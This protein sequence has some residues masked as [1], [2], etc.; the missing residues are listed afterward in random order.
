[1]TSPLDL[2]VEALASALRDQDLTAAEVAD[3]AIA[4]HEA[5]GESLGAYKHFDADGAREA[6][7]AAD[8]RLREPDAPPLCGIPVSVKDL[9]G[10]EGMPTFAGSAR[11]LPGAWSRDAWLV[12]KLREQGAILMGKTHTVEFAYGG[13]G[14]NP[15]WGTPRN[16]WDAETHRIPGGSSAGAGVSLWEGSALIALGS[17]TGGSIRIP[18]SMTGTV[19]HKQ[20]FGRWSTEGV[21]PLS[22]TLDTVGALTRTVEDSVYFFGAL[23]PEWGDPAMLRMQLSTL[24]TAAQPIG[25]PRCAIWDDCQPD[26]AAVLKEA[27]GEL[28]RVGWA[29]V[30][31]DGAILD[32]ARDLYMSGGIPG[33]ELVDF[34]ARD[35]PEWP[36]ILHP[37][38]GER[39]ASAPAIESEKYRSSLE[40]RDA[41]LRRAD[42]LFRRVDLLALPTAMVTP[43]PVE[44]L[45]ALDRYVETNTAALRP[46]CPASML[47]LCAV[48]LPVG[49]DAAGMPVGLQ[50]VAAN[51]H[52]E[53]LLGAALAVEKVLGGAQ[54]RLGRPPLP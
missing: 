49:L 13:V 24:A 36:G 54:E 40:A 20:T 43:P 37:T 5:H 47:G 50:L 15:H 6:A 51:D 10:V 4:R 46:T 33:A 52:D 12:A 30:D 25:V 7:E 11:Q 26:I 18:A 3:E 35:L 28:A 1:M 22:T 41:L 21:V 45:S 32:E 39:I 31:V 8:R 23:D 14:I 44:D 38:V 16:P 9:Y 53:T 17:D 42:E 29:T 34:L 2:S 19:G 48:T 27:L